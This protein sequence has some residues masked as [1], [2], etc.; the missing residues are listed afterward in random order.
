MTETVTAYWNPF[1]SSA[2]AALDGMLFPYPLH[3][4]YALTGLALLTILYAWYAQEKILPA[5][6]RQSIL[7]LRL[8]A[9]IGVVLLLLNPYWTKKRPDPEAFR[10]AVLSDLSGSMHFA[11]LRDGRSRQAFLQDTLSEQVEGSW[12][13]RLQDRYDVLVESFSDRL[14]GRPDDTLSLQPGL[15]AVG[16]SLEALFEREARRERPLGALILM[17]DGI[18]HEGDPA[19]EAAR[20]YREAGIPITVIGI[21][22]TR[23]PGDVALAFVQP[24]E[25][26]VLGEKMELLLQ[27]SNRFDQPVE[28]EIELLDGESV[29]ESRTVR[30]EA[31][32]DSEVEWETVPLRPGFQVYRARVTEPVAGDRNPANDIA[33]AAVEVQEPER[34]QVLYLGARLSNEFRFLRMMLKQSDEFSLSGFVRLGEEQYW[35]SGFSEKKES[36][37]VS[38]FPETLDW[39]DYSGV[40]LDTTV[41]D[42]LPEELKEGL[43]RFLA[44]R[45]GGMLLLG[46][47]SALPESFQFL[48]PVRSF[49]Q[50]TIRQRLFMEALPAPVFEGTVAGL[51]NQAPGLALPTGDPAAVARE[52][53]LA[54]RPVLTLRV[55]EGSLLAVQAYGAGRVA[56]LGTESTWRWRMAGSRGLESYQLFWDSLL[57]WLTD[58]GKPRVEYALQGKVLSLDEPASME[59]SVRGAD[60]L[61]S[62]D[63]RVQVDLRAPDGELLPSG[64][65][66]PDPLKPGRFEGGSLLTKPGEYRATYTIT[67]PDGEIMTQD[68]YFAAAHAGRENTDLQFR[69]ADLR[70]VARVSGGAYF[71]YH[72]LP[73]ATDLTLSANLPILSERVYWTRNVFFLFLVM[74]CMGAEWFLR[75]RLG[76]R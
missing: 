15:T 52:L 55:G 42:E 4:A 10:V 41:V 67:F 26:A 37:P 66:A 65:L 31:G 32:T 40:V 20:L 48:L 5:H 63:A 25:E 39:W 75:R 9:L 46:P 8:L 43:L 60:F 33:F 23:M 22:E 17:S 49:D 1:G 28:M 6:Y 21:G 13:G 57:R 73:D 76:L 71:P 51:L 69:E 45:G 19:V 74:G 56:Y 29:L 61:P 36:E 38:G 34:R 14:R 16:R 3:W 72:A 27:V 47:P 59:V 2:F 12:L 53:S 18:N 68:I 58:G 54:A 11:D 50:L 24:P 7:V 30:V 70:D 35:Q 62:M 44:D 64:L